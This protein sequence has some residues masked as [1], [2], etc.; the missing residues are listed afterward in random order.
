[1]TNPR[2]PNTGQASV[3]RNRD[4]LVR[5]SFKL[6]KL[7]IPNTLDKVEKGH[8]RGVLRML[9]DADP[10]DRQKLLEGQIWAMG[11]ELKFLNK[12]QRSNCVLVLKEWKERL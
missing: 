3:L 6:L 4:S 10:Q 9:G 2:S 11:Q 7:D 12:N 5:D 8:L 1:M